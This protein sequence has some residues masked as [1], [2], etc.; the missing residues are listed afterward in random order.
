MEV[1]MGVIDQT[2]KA[3]ER[4]SKAYDP[5]WGAHPQPRLAV[6][7]CMDP[8]LSDLPAILGLKHADMDVIR[9]GGPAVTDGVLA[10]LI[11]STRV[12]GSKEI[13]ILNHTVCGFTGFTDAELNEKFSKL[14]G[15]SSP[16]PM[17]FFAY[18]DPEQHT[19]EQ[20]KIIRSH[21]WISKDVPVRGFVFDVET[22]RLREVMAHDLSSVAAHSP[23]LASE[24]PDDQK[25][26]NASEEVK[27]IGVNAK[28]I[29]SIDVAKAP[30]NIKDRLFRLRK[31]TVE[32]GGIVAWHSHADRPAIIYIIDGEINEYAS[33]RTTPIMHKPGDV[34]AEI[35]I[36]HWWK[37]LGDKTVVLLS[38]DLL[39]Q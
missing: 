32:P 1:V 30:F 4:Y 27:D 10:E 17:S 28:V 25:T 20:I 13:M 15:D 9:T 21:P 8:R 16:A 29:A 7:T 33:N 14:T 22:G 23:A 12:L 6:V 19:K 37:N 5:K 24:C 38:A 39:R 26:P 31:M 35:E 11:V 36:S 34:V 3:N 18:K 2:L